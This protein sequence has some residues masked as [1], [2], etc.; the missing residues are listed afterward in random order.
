MTTLLH[1]FCHFRQL[2]YTLAMLLVDAG[3]F[4]QLSLRSRVALAAESLRRFLPTRNA[5]DLVDLSL[6]VRARDG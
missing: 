3:H 1:L 2:G 4:L 6:Q 5:E